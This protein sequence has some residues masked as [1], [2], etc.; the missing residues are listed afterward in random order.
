MSLLGKFLALLNIAGAVCLAVLLSMTNAKREVWARS[1]VL[2][3]LAGGHP[4]PSQ[5]P[6]YPDGLP[7]DD[8]D[9]DERANK[10]VEI[11]TDSILREHY[12]GRSGKA[13]PNE[14]EFRTDDGKWIR[15]QSDYVLKLRKQ[16]AAKIDAPESS[17]AAVRVELLCR[18]LLPT[19]D[20]YQDRD[21]PSGARLRG[22]DSLVTLQSHLVSNQINARWRWRIRRAILDTIADKEKDANVKFAEA[23]PKNMR[24]IGF[25]PYTELLIAALA[26]YKNDKGED[27]AGALAVEPKLLDEALT[28]AAKKTGPD[29]WY[30]HGRTRFGTFMRT[31]RKAA[32]DRSGDDLLAEVY[33]QIYPLVGPEGLRRQLER[34]FRP[35]LMALRNPHPKDSPLTDKDRAKIYAVFLDP[36]GDEAQQL[37]PELARKVFRTVYLDTL[38]RDFGEPCRPYAEALIDIGF[39]NADFK[40]ALLAAARDADWPRTVRKLRVPKADKKTFEERKDLMKLT[41]EERKKEQAFRDNADKDNPATYD[42]WDT[43]PKDF[44]KEFTDAV[45]LGTTVN[46]AD[47]GDGPRVVAR[48][49]IPDPA[50]PDEFPDH[51]LLL[52]VETYPYLEKN[53]KQSDRDNP[54]ELVFLRKLADSKD[55]A[56][57]IVDEAY[58]RALDGIATQLREQF[59]ALFRDRKDPAGKKFESG[60]FRPSDSP[61]SRRVAVARLLGTLSDVAAELEGKENT[62]DADGYTP[63][64]WR[65]VKVVGIR[66]MTGELD[67]QYDATRRLTAEAAELGGRDRARFAAVHPMAVDRNRL[68]LQ[69]IENNKN[70]LELFTAQIASKEQLVEARKK[71]R[72]YYIDEFK[73]IRGPDPKKREQDPPKTTLDA[74]AELEKMT[75]ELHEARLYLRDVD[76]RNRDMLEAIRYL[77]LQGPKRR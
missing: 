11:L 22:H 28:E 5:P 17:D 64:L 71:D 48:T 16:L 27:V 75:R 72:D 9:L 66:L 44:P 7:M 41:S 10:R 73:K 68:M 69:A 58:S 19:V 76:Q 30:N 59:E 49:R 37:T 2:F 29:R 12:Y 54:P 13:D 20:F 70:N 38:V 77:E 33:A 21:S 24:A 43:V 62:P 47:R 26:G 61:M 40:A 18:I 74:L 50:R 46:L 55:S 6:D 4:N 45:R 23:F 3:G 67:R 52:V 25:G 15:T 63:A 56:D 60:P 65:A 35:T 57:K 31:I 1:V 39:E 32:P 42:E 34:A 53:G 51:Y 8:K 36:K 14:K